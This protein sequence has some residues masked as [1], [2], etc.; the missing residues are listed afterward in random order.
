MVLCCVYYLIVMIPMPEGS[1]ITMRNCYPFRTQLQACLHE[2][3]SIVIAIE[4][5]A[6]NLA[7]ASKYL[8]NVA[9][10]HMLIHNNTS[11]KLMRSTTLRISKL[12]ISEGIHRGTWGGFFRLPPWSLRTMRDAPMGRNWGTQPQYNTPHLICKR[13]GRDD[14]KVDHYYTTW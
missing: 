14:Y 9:I 5:P 3:I 8:N 7:Q 6:L 11:N 2:P 4:H 10:I 13:G 12:L 1:F